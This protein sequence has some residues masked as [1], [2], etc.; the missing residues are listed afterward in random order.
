[1]PLL[2][3]DS[4]VQLTQRATSEP[5]LAKQMV[6]LFLTKVYWFQWFQTF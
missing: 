4:A 3:L 2:N 6:V 1:M 5:G